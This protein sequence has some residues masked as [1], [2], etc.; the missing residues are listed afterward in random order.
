MPIYL[1]ESGVMEFSTEWECD[2]SSSISPIKKLIK[3]RNTL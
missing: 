1:S 3:T 2:M